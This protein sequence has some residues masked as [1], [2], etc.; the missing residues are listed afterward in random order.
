MP[1]TMNVRGQRSP[2]RHAIAK[3]PAGGKKTIKRLLGYVLTNYLWSLLAV[4]VCI[5]ITSVTTLTSSLFTK[6]L[7]DDYIMPMTE[8]QSK[9]YYVDK[10]KEN[11]H[12]S[13]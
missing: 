7:I 9:I 5:V 12:I 2:Q 3:M 6:T 1:P 8:R 4:L 11:E 10:T 13:K